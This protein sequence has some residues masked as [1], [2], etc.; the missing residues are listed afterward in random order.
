MG[1]F[2][3]D[4]TP[5][6]WRTQLAY[7]GH[8]GIHNFSFGTIDAYFY[9][10]QAKVAEWA[11]DRVLHVATAHG[12]HKTWAFAAAESALL[13]LE[14]LQR[15]GPVYSQ[16]RLPLRGESK[17]QELAYDLDEVHSP[18]SYPSKKKRYQRLT[19]P[20]RWLE[21]HNFEVQVLS[22]S[23]IQRIRSL[24]ERWC[25]WKLEQP[26]TYRMMFPNRR[27]YECCLRAS[28]GEGL[29]YRG[30]A[31]VGPGDQVVAARVVYIEENVAFDL[32]QF[33]ASWEL[34]SNF[35]EYFA[36][37]TMAQLWDDG[38]KLLNCGASLNKHLSSF[39]SHWPHTYVSHFAYSRQKS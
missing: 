34:P 20:R 5:A 37:V 7:T 15:L 28:L 1:F 23:H 19:Y 2:T 9:L 24:H 30:F 22:I 17:F 21:Q 10:T 8:S 3:R 6:D 11:S 38:I 12:Q 31:A 39:K 35:A 14:E 4:L 13:K 29:G 16:L 25:A 27:Y 26:Q 18:A 36:S 33:C 32:A